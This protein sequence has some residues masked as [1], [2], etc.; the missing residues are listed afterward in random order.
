MTQNKTL[1]KICTAHDAY[2]RL[3]TLHTFNR[4]F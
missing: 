3:G 1:N 2:F 4:P